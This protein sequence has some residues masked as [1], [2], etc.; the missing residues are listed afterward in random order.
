[1][2]RP[3]VVLFGMAA[4]VALTGC[5]S[6]VDAARK[7]TRQGTSAFKAQG[8][9]VGR[10][11]RRI[12]ILSTAIVHDANGTAAVVAVRNTGPRAMAD[13]P[14][15][16]DV[17]GAGRRSIFRNN[18][19]GLENSLTHVPLLL[20]GQRVDWVNDQVLP[21]GTAVGLVA[22]IGAGR[23]LGSPPPRIETRSVHLS[24]DDVSGWTAD[25]T[26][27]N[28]SHVAQLRL[29]LFATAR[30]QGKIVAAGRAI[31]TRLMPGK[32]ARF[33]AYFIGNPHGAQ[34]SISAPP[35]IIAK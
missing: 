7:I 26:A 28:A 12:R 18:S 32:S 11:D 2:I 15:A 17:L 6:T 31:I 8:L 25:G 22:R 5:E 19:P 21:T 4:L 33:H 13:A 30:H 29:V 35:S 34:L 27:V 10:V 24:Y 1:M 16:I 3:A 20:P 23:S 14:I 9:S